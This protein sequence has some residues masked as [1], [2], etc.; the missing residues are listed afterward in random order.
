MHREL[1]LDNL[2]VLQLLLK[3]MLLGDIFLIEVG[4]SV[5][6][7]PWPQNCRCQLC[8]EEMCKELL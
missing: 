5:M 4:K 7:T 8:E 3:A 1:G 2:L 6:C